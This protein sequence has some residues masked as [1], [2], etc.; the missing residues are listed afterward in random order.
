MDRFPD[1]AVLGSP[2]SP[3]RSPYS[4][5]ATLRPAPRRCQLLER[6]R[7]CAD[8]D[9]EFFRAC[10]HALYTERSSNS[11]GGTGAS[12]ES[13]FNRIADG[14]ANLDCNTSQEAPEDALRRMLVYLHNFD[15]REKMAIDRE[16]SLNRQYAALE[17]ELSQSMPYDVSSSPDSPAFYIPAVQGLTRLSCIGM[18]ISAKE[19]EQTNQLYD[20]HHH[21]F[22]TDGVYRPKLPSLLREGETIEPV[23]GLLV[24]TPPSTPL[25]LSHTLLDS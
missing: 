2:E 18:V 17:A 16:E 1:S 14:A 23:D 6:L 3:R 4:S 10:F 5:R 25:A 24:L 21:N 19:E 9:R 8:L 20:I 22:A 7:R 13:G 15:E 11:Y 12:S